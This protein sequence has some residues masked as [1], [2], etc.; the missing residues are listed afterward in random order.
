MDNGI[1]RTLL[2]PSGKAAKFADELRGG[3]R[4]TNE[5]QI[6]KDSQGKPLPLNRAQRRY[7]NGYI[8]AMADRAE[9][10]KS[11]KAIK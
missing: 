3:K 2:N 4:Y 10:Y 8:T 11:K 6:K 1:V 5:M 9:A 7:R